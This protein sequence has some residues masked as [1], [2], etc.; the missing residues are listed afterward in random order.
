LKAASIEVQALARS[1]GLIKTLCLRLVKGNFIP[2]IVTKRVPVVYVLNES[3]IKMTGCDVPKGKEFEI[4]GKETI[5][6]VV[7]D[8]SL[9]SLHSMLNPVA[10]TYYPELLENHLVKLPNGNNSGTID[11]IK[12]KWE[13]FL[14]QYPFEYSFLEEVFK[15]YTNIIL[16]RSGSSAVYP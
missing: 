9:K 6:G 11:F 12:S 3:V 10:L 5:I 8:F 16:R 14:P 13:D 1:S 15:K 4:I 2:S 7:R